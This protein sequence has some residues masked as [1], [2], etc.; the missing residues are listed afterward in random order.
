M[1]L[2]I[3]AYIHIVF[4]RG[5]IHCL[6]HIQKEWPRNGILRVEIVRNVPEN[7]SI[8]NSY[9][10]EYRDFQIDL[11]EQLMG[12]QTSN[13]TTALNETE[14]H[15]NDTT[16]PSEEYTGTDLHQPDRTGVG[17]EI[18]TDEK[19]VDKLPDIEEH[20]VYADNNT[21]SKST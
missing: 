9:E 8:I 5:P 7:Y 21:S 18:N 10:K 11:D 2:F 16:L 19:I 20:G 3:L 15:E 1:V 6:E 14:S 13:T 4:A 12:N 17:Q